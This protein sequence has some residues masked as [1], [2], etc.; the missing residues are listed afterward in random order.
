MG[1]MNAFGAITFTKFMD[2]EIVYE[3]EVYFEMYQEIG[4]NLGKLVRT[5]VD[6]DEDGLFRNDD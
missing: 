6:F 3:S 1:I 4:M 5:S 2:D